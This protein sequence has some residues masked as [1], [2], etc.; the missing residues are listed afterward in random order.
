MNAHR[1]NDERDNNSCDAFN[2]FTIVGFVFGEFFT[3]NNNESRNSINETMRS[4]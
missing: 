4:I 1:D 3:N 2:L